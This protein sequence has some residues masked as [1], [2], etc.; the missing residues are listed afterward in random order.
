MRPLRP[1]KRM[2]TGSLWL[3]F[4]ALVLIAGVAGYALAR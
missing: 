3:A 2:H 1:A 4:L